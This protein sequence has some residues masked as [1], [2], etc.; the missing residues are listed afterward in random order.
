MRSELRSKMRLKLRS[1]LRLT[2]KILKGGSM[3]KMSIPS[4]GVPPKTLI[5]DNVGTPRTPSNGPPKTLIDNVGTPRNRGSRKRVEPPQP[6]E[7][8]PQILRKPIANTIVADLLRKKNAESSN[9]QNQSKKTSTLNTNQ[10]ELTE[11]L[12]KKIIGNESF[13]LGRHLNRQIINGKL[14]ESGN[15]KD[16]TKAR[17]EEIL[18]DD[19]KN[20]TPGQLENIIQNAF[21][22]KQDYLRKLS[23]KNKFASLNNYNKI[24]FKTSNTKEIIPSSNIVKDIVSTYKPLDFKKAEVPNPNS[25]SN[26]NQKRVEDVVSIIQDARIPDETTTKSTS[27][28]SNSA[29]ELLE[30]NRNIEPK[31]KTASNTQ[32][33]AGEARLQNKIPSNINNPSNPP[34][35]N[36]LNLTKT[37]EAAITKQAPIQALESAKRQNTELNPK[38][39]KLSEDIKLIQSIIDENNTELK[40]LETSE[41]P[42]TLELQNKLE[43]IKSARSNISESEK[44]LEGYNSRII[45]LRD[46]RDKHVPF[47]KE[48][49]KVDFLVGDLEMNA[50]FLKYNIIGNNEILTENEKSPVILK[51]KGIN[52]KIS[53]YNKI[54][55]QKQEQASAIQEPKQAS[56]NLEPKRNQETNLAPSN[57][58]TLPKPA[59]TTKLAPSNTTTIK[60]QATNLAPTKNQAAILAPSNTT[61]LQKQEPAL[62]PALAINLAPTHT[63]ATNQE[64]ATI[65][66][67]KQ[68]PAPATNQVP[69]KLVAAPAPEPTATPAQKY[70]SDYIFQPGIAQNDTIIAQTNAPKPLTETVA[71]KPFILKENTN[72]LTDYFLKKNRFSRF[73]NSEGNIDY[74]LFNDNNFLRQNFGNLKQGENASKLSVLAANPENLEIMKNALQNVFEIKTQEEKAKADAEAKAKE[75]ELELVKNK[76]NLKSLLGTKLESKSL[77]IHKVIDISAILDILNPKNLQNKNENIIKTE[78]I[79]NLLIPQTNEFHGKTLTTQKMDKPFAEKLAELFIKLPYNEVKNAILEY[80]KTQ[81]KSLEQEKNEAARKAVNKAEKE[82]AQKL[83][84]GP[85]IDFTNEKYKNQLTDYFLSTDRSGEQ[86]FK[87][88]LR[89]NGSL[90]EDIIY[91]EGLEKLFPTSVQL[92]DR[93]VQISSLM[94]NTNSM[95]ALKEA[96]VKARNKLKPIEV[97]INISKDKN[98]NTTNTTNII[99]KFMSTLGDRNPNIKP[100]NE[101]HYSNLVN[102]IR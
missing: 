82:K 1:K 69:I 96:V 40:N 36:I 76:E 77:Q 5:G 44:I 26:L 16:K 9:T 60:N 32:N 99:N 68:E 100:N 33:I 54:L 3:P 88:L 28:P 72:E 64:Q 67:P 30:I 39:S 51:Y 29:K 93:K 89:T 19:I 65:I 7:P 87:K 95:L 17:I 22:I 79:N 27:T 34:T 18:G 10:T 23:N 83:K 90:E 46:L 20:L 94:R 48:W 38:L 8:L 101:I 24:V 71:P 45:N 35:Q 70:P 78:I 21:I 80:R 85:P 4:N 74:K 50:N 61:T 14:T 81:S 49:N 97:N 55:T 15:M 11:K 66:A 98:Q 47:S 37:Q 52:D 59:L 86:R 58:T 12:T 42:E 102:P 62:E 75:Q 31:I 53:L 92:G 25:I 13:I 43:A 57:T 84:Y 6:P 91:K 73:I 56:S 2:A 63:Q 41:T